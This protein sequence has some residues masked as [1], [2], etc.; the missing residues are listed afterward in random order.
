MPI[1]TVTI[2]FS[3]T[4]TPTDLLSCTASGVSEVTIDC[5]GI[6]LENSVS[7]S[8]DGGPLHSCKSLKCRWYDENL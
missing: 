7:C 2:H 3:I 8:F 4:F 1:H 6:E 5:T